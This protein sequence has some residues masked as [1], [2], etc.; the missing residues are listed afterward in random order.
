MNI[1]QDDRGQGLPKRSK[2][3]C[4]HLSPPRDIYDK[5]L[6]IQKQVA[7]RKALTKEIN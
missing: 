2:R 4:F 6:I 7:L 1:S 5:T 3:F